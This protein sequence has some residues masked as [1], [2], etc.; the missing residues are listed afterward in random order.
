VEK[1]SDQDCINLFV[2]IIKTI[3]KMPKG[4]IVL[5]KLKTLHG[6]CVFDDDLIEIDYRKEFILTLIHEVIHYLNPNWTETM[7]LYAEKRVI[8]VISEDDVICLLKTA[9]KKMTSA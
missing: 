9:I 2:E 3:N 1:L 8:N 5:K 7:V 4:F 6:T